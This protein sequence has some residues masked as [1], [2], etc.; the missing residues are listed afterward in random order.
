MEDRH[1]GFKRFVCMILFV[2]VVPLECVVGIVRGVRDRVRK[3][4][5]ERETAEYWKVLKGLLV[6]RI[7]LSVECDYIG[8]TEE[9]AAVSWAKR[10]R[11]AG[12][13]D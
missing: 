4:R 12:Y 9:D 7:A 2:I 3:R 13:E 6:D 1:R 8:L 5:E 11:G 10:G